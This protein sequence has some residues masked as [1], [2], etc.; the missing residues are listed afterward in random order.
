MLI[1]ELEEALS[2]QINRELYSSY[3]YL[4]MSAYFEKEN[5]PGCAHW[6]R[7]QAKEEVEHAMKYYTYLFSRGGSIN[8]KEIGAAPSH[9]NSVLDVFESAYKQEQEISR[10][11]DHLVTL[12]L[13]KQDHATTQ[14]LQWFVAE[15][16]AEEDVAS[17]LVERLKRVGDDPASLVFLDNELAARV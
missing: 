14:F 13:S 17:T 1:P 8:F 6:M 9:W 7:L 2:G 3:V 11:T 15:Q 5:L 16:V 4:A 12:A 10:D